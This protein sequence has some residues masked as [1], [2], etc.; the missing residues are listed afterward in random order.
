MKW[1]RPVTLEHLLILRDQYPDAKLVVGN[2]ELG[3]EMK[4]GNLIYPVMIHINEIPELNEI[5]VK[6]DAIIVGAA[7]TLDTIDKKCEELMIEKKNSGVLRELRKMLKWFAGQQLRNV[8]CIGGNIMTGS[9]ISDLNP[10]LMASGSKIVLVNKLGSREF[11]FTPNFYSG[12]RKTI[13]KP[14]EIL[15]S[16]KIPF[17]ENDSEYFYAYKQSR[18]RE[19]DIAIVNCAM[20]Y[21]VNKETGVISQFNIAFGGMSF[22][23]V[24]APKTI[25]HFLDKKVDIQLIEDSS[26][27]L[28]ED[29]PLTPGR[30]RS[31]DPI[32][33]FPLYW[34]SL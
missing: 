16:I 28:M 24:F 15:L 11:A 21:S 32:S 26:K 22:K 3:V 20:H 23:T 29:L 13:G 9:P 10:I 8:A 27:L 1:F 25:R 19:D 6:D 34:I 17:L 4:F 31:Y 18:R 5:I 33:T 12:Y 30:T 7:V 2:T 14:E